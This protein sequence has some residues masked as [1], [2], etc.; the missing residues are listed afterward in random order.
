MLREM[1]READQLE[2]QGNR[3]AQIR[4]LRI[5]ADFPDM[6]DPDAVPA[7]APDGLRQRAI[8]AGNS[9][10]KTP[11]ESARQSMS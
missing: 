6:L 5:E 1:P 10:W 8:T 3:Q 2:R 9:T 7:P 4:V 11:T